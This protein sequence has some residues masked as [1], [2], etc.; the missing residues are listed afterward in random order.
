MEN[1]KTTEIKPGTRV[2]VDWEDSKGQ[3]AIIQDDSHYN[4][5]RNVS[6]RRYYNVKKIS[7]GDT[8]IAGVEQVRIDKQYY[9]NKRLNK[10][11]NG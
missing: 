5:L 11:L 6:T 10:L 2:I 7:G 1:E 9:R 4:K 8:L 3:V